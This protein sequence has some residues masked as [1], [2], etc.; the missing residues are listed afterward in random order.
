MMICF[1]TLDNC[2]SIKLN[3]VYHSVIS[4]FCTLDNCLSIKPLD[5]PV[6]S[7]TGF[8]TLDNCLS[9]KRLLHEKGVSLVFALS[10]I[11]YQ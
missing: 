1:C 6:S 11:A 7:I 8:C 5:A 2:L 4:C 3:C 10:I 9:I